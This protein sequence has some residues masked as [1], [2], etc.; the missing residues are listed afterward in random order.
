[1]YL[2]VF[3]FCITDKYLVYTGVDDQTL[4]HGTAVGVGYIF[5]GFNIFSA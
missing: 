4:T 5:T 3:V 1:M 2:A